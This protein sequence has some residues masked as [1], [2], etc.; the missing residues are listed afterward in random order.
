MAPDIACAHAVRVHGDD[1]V[2]EVGPARLVLED[3][4]R[5]EG[6]VAVKGYVDWQ[7]DRLVL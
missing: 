1:H 3:Q 7:I 2:V 5:I 6:T 4:L